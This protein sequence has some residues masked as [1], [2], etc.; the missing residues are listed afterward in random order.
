MTKFK[1]N[2]NGKRPKWKN[3]KKEDDKNGRQPNGR[4]PKW[5]TTKM[6]DNQYGR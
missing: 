5:K 6:K 3:T 1:D 4:C 2:Q